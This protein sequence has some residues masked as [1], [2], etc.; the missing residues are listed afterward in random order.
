MMGW[1]LLLSLG[2]VLAGVS[3]SFLLAHRLDT[4]ATEALVESARSDARRL[5]EFSELSLD[6]G[7][8]GLLIV[9]ERLR[10]VSLSEPERFSAKVMS[11][12]R[13]IQAIDFEN[14]VF[15][16]RAGPSAGTALL[17]TLNIGGPYPSYERL[18]MLIEAGPPDMVVLG[19][20]FQG[21][22]GRLKASLATGLSMAGRE[23][24]LVAVFDIEGFLLSMVRSVVPDGLVLRVSERSDAQTPLMGGVEPLANALATFAYSGETQGTRWFYEWDMLP[25][26]RT[27]YETSPGTMIRLGGSVLFLL[28]GLTM[29]ALVLMNQRVAAAVEKRTAELAR[30]RDQAELANRTKSDFLANMSHELRTPLNAIIG[31]SEILEAQVFGPDAWERYRDYATDIRQSGRH[32][33]RLINDLLDLSK[34]E[35]GALSLDE[36]YVS[37]REIIDGAVRLVHERARHAGLEMTV[38]DVPDS[39]VLHCD[40]LR[41]KQIMLNLLSNAVKFTP[42]GGMVTVA[43]ALRKSGEFALTVTDT[44]VGM[45]E[46]DIPIALA[47]FGQVERDPSMLEAGTGLGLPL[48]SNLAMLHGADLQI[49]STQGQGTRVSVVFPQNRVALIDDIYGPQSAVG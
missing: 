36:D 46:S 45:S 12:I 29:V 31:F 48:A 1:L 14:V 47:K 7:E 35:A 6:R 25:A 49:S 38:G 34:A 17:Q 9:A 26:Y 18:A 5:T 30:A 37:P 16:P 24:M 41:V 10:A 43:G 19:R 8:T 4:R 32:L 44:G 3:L 33:L 13:H 11:S 39:H 27:A 21:S 42:R 40:E 2:V 20:S 22:D 23:G 28:I 15:V